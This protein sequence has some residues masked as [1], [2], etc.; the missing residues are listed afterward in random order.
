[1]GES[2]KYLL[3]GGG[4]ASVSAAKTIRE[5]DK[6]GRL[7]I[8]SADRHMPYDRPPLSKNFLSDNSMTH[9]DVSSKYDHWY[10][11]NSIEVKLASPIKGVDRRNHFAVLEDG[12]QITYEKLLIATGSRPNTLASNHLDSDTS[13]TLRTIDD[14]ISIRQAMQT[15]KKVAVIGTGFLGPEVA[16]QCAGKGIET[17][18]VSRGK[19]IWDQFASP[20]LGAFLNEY[21]RSHGVRIFTEHKIGLVQ[22]D[23]VVTEHNEIIPVDFSLQAIGVTQNTELADDAGIGFL[24]DDGIK[25]DNH[26][27]SFADP[28]IYAAGDVAYFQDF[29][30]DHYAH[31]EHHL[32]AQWTGEV[33]GANMAGD[34]VPYDKVPYFFSDF[35]DLHMVLRGQAT[36]TQF[37]TVLGSFEAAEFIELYADEAGTLQMGISISRDESTLD[38]IA[39]RLAELVRQKVQANTVTMADFPRPQAV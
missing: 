2:T 30:L 37:T 24:P 1:M 36:T 10:T 3:I 16:S 6:T 11:D 17:T 34:P 21:Y 8:V 18:I 33:A 28:D 13:F 27:R 22:S 26:F 5:R 25:V 20:A 4:I 14:A 29:V 19:H 9:D 7:M 15:A 35:F 38:P 12:S 31:Y 39:D 23:R 32:N